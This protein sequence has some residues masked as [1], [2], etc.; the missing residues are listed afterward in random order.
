MLWTDYGIV[1]PS[2]WTT[3]G[4]IKFVARQVWGYTHDL[5]PPYKIVESILPD[6]A[7]VSEEAL[8]LALEK[9]YRLHNPS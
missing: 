6:D 7:F 1:V 9:F 8:R 2:L 4:S 5:D 3:N